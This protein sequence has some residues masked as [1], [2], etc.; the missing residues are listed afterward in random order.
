M[1]TFVLEI[2]T[3]ELPS[4][5]LAGEEAYLSQSFDTALKENFLEHGSIRVYTTPR[6][7]AVIIDNLSPVQPTREEEV[8]GPPARIAWKDGVPSKALEGF[9]RTNGVE[10]KDVY[11]IKTPK[12]E[13][14][15][16]KKTVGGR[17]AGDILA[18]VCPGIISG[19]PFAKRMRWGTSSFTY[20]R[21]MHWIL[22]LLDDSVVSFEVGPV[23]S[24]R[25]TRGHRIHG[26]GPFE[27]P[28]AS[29]YIDVV[30]KKGGLVLDGAERRRIIIEGADRQA[31]AVGGRVL[32]TEGLLNEVCGLVEHPAPLLGDFDKIYLEVPRE[33]LVTS[34]QVNQ[35]S[36]GLEDSAGNLLPHF[37]TVLNL[38]PPDVELVK[39]GW[40]RVLR[41]RLEDARFFWHEDL[42]NSFDKWLEELEHVVFIRGLG[43]MG[44]K[45]RRLEKLCRAIAEKC[46]PAVADNAARAGRLSKAVL[47]TNMVG[48]FDTLQGVMGG[49]YAKRMGENDAVASAVSEQ[50]LPAGPDSPLPVSATGAILSIADKVDTM[51]GCFGLGLIPT[52]AADPNALRRCALGII[53]IVREF[54]F[55][56]DMRDLFALAQEAYGDIEWKLSPTEALDRLMDFF[57]LRLRNF[58][59]NLGKETTLVDAA[60]GAGVRDVKTCDLRLEALAA[61]RKEPGYTEAV[62]TFKRV[63]NIIRKQSDGREGIPAVWRKSLLQEEP[64]KKLA[65]VLDEVLPE[66]DNLWNGQNYAGILAT[67]KKL[68]PFVDAFFD[69]VMVNCDDAALRNNRLALL[70]AMADRFSRVADFA[71]LQI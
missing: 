41:A 31:K 71:A 53:R 42:K 52:G 1:A 21:P 65:D 3:E 8:S 68:R 25:T 18:D 5:F 62:Q 4:R 59:Q 6:R 46:D 67:L 27:V 33:V 38:T 32:Y 22:A 35:K 11:T 16:V 49:I 26:A 60:L 55:S 64:E 39:H 7:A 48:E 40:E 20:A 57:S 10:V 56:L 66:L 23:K 44:D 70:K 43:T 51:A 19:V 28:S 12:G 45:T 63:A 61:F 13:Y 58:Y 30:T 9:A 37:V 50:Y 17:G 29:D 54:G 24:G 15:A 34:M 69:G 2:G 14:V 36:F 47:V